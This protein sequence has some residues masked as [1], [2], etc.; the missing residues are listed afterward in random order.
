VSDV[1]LETERLVLRLPRLDDAPAAAEYLADP[2]VMR[3]LGGETVPP[4]EAPAVLQKW[5]DRWD[6]NGVGHFVIE[7][8]EDGA[9]LGRSGILVW[10]TRTWTHS[11]FAEAGEHAQPELGWTLVRRHWGHGYATEAS[12]AVR[13]WARRERGIGRLI[14]LVNPAN[15]ASQRVAERLG[16]RPEETVSLFDSGEAVVWVHP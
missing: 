5:L 11:S 1:R 12:R 3:F 8:R 7:R 16:A 10:D 4:E 14:S 9:F 2:Q 15:A 13:D 6:A